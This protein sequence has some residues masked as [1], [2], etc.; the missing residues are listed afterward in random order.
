M[1]LI[2]SR[3]PADAELLVWD[4]TVRPPA[5]V[6]VVVNATSIGLSDPEA[7][8]NLDLTG[9]PSGAVVADVIPNPPRTAL[10]RDAEGRGHVVLDG[11]GMLVEQGVI[12]IRHWTG[13]DADAAV[14]RRALH[15]A[16]GLTGR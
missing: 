5:D 3:T 16:L 2:R 7:R 10:V 6:S 8:L 4:H 9:L 12:S 14:M 11:L 13:V 1:S 15:D